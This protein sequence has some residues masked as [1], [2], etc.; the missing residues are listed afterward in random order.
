LFFIVITAIM[1]IVTSIINPTYARDIVASSAIQIGSEKEAV[2][3]YQKYGGGGYSF[4]SALV[5]LFPML[6]YYYKNNE[7]SYWNKWHLLFFTIILFF[8][9]IRIQIFANI[10]ISFIALVLSLLGRKNVRKARIY[11]LILILIIILIPIHYYVGFFQTVGNWFNTGSENYYKMNDMAQFLSKGGTIEGTGTGT[12]AGRYP[13]LWSEFISSPIW[14]GGEGNNHLFWM[15]KLA[16]FGL[17]GTI[18]FIYFFYK[19]IKNNLKYYDKE[20]SF[21]FLLSMLSIIFLG[22]VKAHSGY[23]VWF[24]FFCIIPGFYYLPLIKKNN[25]NPLPKN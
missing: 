17:L 1:S 25:K 15:N 8:A 22:L 3:S 18:P 7:K 2:L 12:R 23:D 20:Y 11:I 10:M 9:L 13:I 6:I 5:C 14:G 21:Y 24:V 16:L 19:F 4:A